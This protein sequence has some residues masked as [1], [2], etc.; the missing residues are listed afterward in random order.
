MLRIFNQ[1]TKKE[2]VVPKVGSMYDKNNLIARVYW[3]NDY[4]DVDLIDVRNANKGYVRIYK[5]T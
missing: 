4:W 5:L 2:I 3:W 1:K